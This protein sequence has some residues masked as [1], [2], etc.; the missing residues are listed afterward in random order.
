[1]I[2]ETDRLVLRNYQQ[3]DILPFVEMA[4]NKIF[5]R[6]Y[7]EQDCMKEKLVNL[8]NDFMQEA[9]QPPRTNYNL[10]IT[11]KPDGQLIGAAGI[12]MQEEYQASVG[13]SLDVEFHSLGLAGEAL[14]AICQFGFSSLHAHRIFAETISENISAIKLCKKLGMRKE[15]EFMQNRYFRGRWWNTVM[16]AMLAQEWRAKQ[17]VEEYR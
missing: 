2:I 7:S 1:M 9:E 13:C 15:A 12:R 11:L 4:R 17:Q 16:Y 5:Q 8:V 10:A 3:S 14:S 6:F